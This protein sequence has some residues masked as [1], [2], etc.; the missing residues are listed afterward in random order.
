MV[1]TSHMWP[2][3]PEMWPVQTEMCLTYFNIVGKYKTF[4]ETSK[5][6]KNPFSPMFKSKLWDAPFKLGAKLRSL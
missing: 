3:A 6:E 5:V 2:G 1:A 4:A